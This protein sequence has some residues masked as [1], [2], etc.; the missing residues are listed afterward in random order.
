M[1]K[2]KLSTKVLA[3]IL[4]AGMVV[5]AVP[6]N[7]FA[8]DGA[9]EGLEV[10]QAEQGDS[11]LSENTGAQ[12]GEGSVSQ[13]SGNETGKEGD[14]G[15]SSP[16]ENGND[17][18]ESGNDTSENDNDT[19]ES[20]NN[21]TGSGDEITEGSGNTLPSDGSGSIS[22]TT[23]NDKNTQNTGTEDNGQSEKNTVQSENIENGGEDNKEDGSVGKEGNKEEGDLEKEQSF[24]DAEF[25]I[26]W[27]D[28][29]N[30]AG[31]RPEDIHDLIQ[32]YGDGTQINDTEY[33][34]LLVETSE[35]NGMD[36]YVYR[37]EDLPVYQ[38]DLVTEI[39][40]SLKQDTE[41]IKGYT[42][43]SEQSFSDLDEVQVQQLLQG[44][45]TPEGTVELEKT[46]GSEDSSYHVN[47]AFGNYL[48]SYEV[49]GTISWLD[50]NGSIRPSMEQYFRD[51]FAILLDGAPYKTFHM[52]YSDDSED[53]SEW[54]YTIKGLFTTK[55]DGTPAVYTL[56]AG[57]AEGYVADNTEI[58]ISGDVK[59]AW[60]EY[61]E[62][63][64]L[65]EVMLYGA[66]QDGEDNT[67]NS[68]NS[69]N[70][71]AKAEYNGNAVAAVIWQDVNDGI[72]HVGTLPVQI[73]YAID[74]GSGNSKWNTVSCSWDNETKA[75]VPDFSYEQKN[76]LVSLG[77]TEEDL[78]SGK[79]S[80]TG[81]NNLN[82]KIQLSGMPSKITTSDAK[83]D[84]TITEK[85]TNILWDVIVT[86]APEASNNSYFFKET[87]STVGKRTYRLT[88]ATE[89]ILNLD[90]RNG[91]SGLSEKLGQKFFDA[92]KLYFN[93]AGTSYALDTAENGALQTYISENFGSNIKLGISKDW[94][95]SKITISGLPWCD[96]N[97]AEFSYCIRVFD[98][99][100]GSGENQQEIADKIMVGDNSGDYY[101]VSYN[102]S[103]VPN[104]GDVYT[105]VYNKGTMI[106]RLTGFT[107][108]QATKIWLDEKVNSEE[109]PQASWSLWRYSG[110]GR[111]DGYQSASPVYTLTYTIDGNNKW[112]PVTT[113]VTQVLSG[114]SGERVS[115]NSLPKYNTDGYPYIYFVKESMASD[116]GYEKVF[117]NVG[118][119][120]TV[121]GDVLPYGGERGKDTSLYNGGV[122]SN[123]M[124][125]ETEASQ[126][127]IWRAAYY[128]DELQDI[129]VV[130]KLQSRQKNNAASEWTDVSLSGSDGNL[131]AATQEI[132][133]F[134]LEELSKKVSLENLPR[135]DVWGKELEYRWIE[136]ALYEGSNRE[137]NLL[138]TPSDDNGNKV[139]SLSE[140]ERNAVDG[141][142]HYVSY[143]A[144]EDSE[145]GLV[146][147]GMI[148]NELQGTTDYYVQKHWETDIPDEL[149]SIQVVLEQR[150][151]DGSLK[152]ELTYTV[153][154]PDA[155]GTDGSNV[156]DG[157]SGADGSNVSDGTNGADGSGESDERDWTLMITGYPDQDGTPDPDR[158]LPK[159]DETGAKY[160]YM[161]TQE[162]IPDKYQGQWG[163]SY[164]YDLTDTS[165]SIDNLQY[166]VNNV[167]ITNSAGGF[168]KIIKVKKEW[169]DD[170]DALNRKPVTIEVYRAADAS[171]QTDDTLL[172]TVTLTAQKEWWQYVSVTEY[173]YTTTDR[174]GNIQTIISKD[175]KEAWSEDIDPATDEKYSDLEKWKRDHFYSN[176]SYYIME[177]GM[178]GE[179]PTSY[180]VDTVNL[181]QRGYPVIRTDKHTYEVL[182]K[183]SG[184]VTKG[185]G[186]DSDGFYTVVNRRIGVENLK[187][188]KV[189]KDGN[190]SSDERMRWEASFK[191]KCVEYPDA[192]GESVIETDKNDDDDQDNN[193]DNSQIS[194]DGDET[195]QDQPN[196]SYY[197]TL[198]NDNG[199][200]VRQLIK[201]KEGSRQSYEVKLTGVTGT[202]NIETVYYCNLPKYDLSGRVIHYD[203]METSPDDILKTEGEY[204]VEDTDITYVSSVQEDS[205]TT[206]SG[207]INSSITDSDI[208]IEK[209]VTNQRI[210]TKTVTFYKK[211]ID[212][213]VFEDGKRPDIYLTIYQLDSD[214]RCDSDN[215]GIPDT[216]RLSD[217]VDRL[218]KKT[219]D[220]TEYDWACEVQMPKY[221]STGRE[222]IYYAVESTHVDTASLDYLPVQYQPSQEDK[223]ADP[224]CKDSEITYENG[225]Y[226]VE[227]FESLAVKPVGNDIWALKENGT[228]VKQLW[229]NITVVGKKV[230]ENVPEGF[231]ADELPKLK[232]IL[233]RKKVSEEEASPVAVAETVER[234]SPGL[235]FDFTFRYEGTNDENGNYV[236]SVSETDDSGSGTTD[237]WNRLLPK[238]DAQTGEL[239]TYSVAEKVTEGVG[240]VGSTEIAYEK[241]PGDIHNYVIT[242]TYRR[243]G[244]NVGNITVSKNWE[245]FPTK[246]PGYQYPE[247]QFTLYRFYK[248]KDGNGYSTPE[249]VATK[250]LNCNGASAVMF[251]DQLIYAPN[252][253]PYIYFVQEK[254]LNG[255]TIASGLGIGANTETC[256]AG[257]ETSWPDQLP[258]SDRVAAAGCS[259]AFTIQRTLS[260]QASGDSGSNPVVSQA[261][262]DFTNTFTGNPITT[263]KGEKVWDD[264]GDVF[265]TRQDLNLTLFR[266]AQKQAGTSVDNA[267][268][269]QKVC[270]VTVTKNQSVI[271]PSEVRSV[272]SSFNQ[273]GTIKYSY[274]ARGDIWSYTFYNLDGYA[275]NSS[276]W[277]YKVVEGTVDYDPENTEDP[278]K[279]TVANYDSVDGEGKPSDGV[280]YEATIISD[281]SIDGLDQCV[282]LGSLKNVNKTS[283]KVTKVWD[284]LENLSQPEVTFALQVSVDGG[285]N[286]KWAKSYFGDRLVSVRPDSE[287]SDSEILSYEYTK[288]I[289]ANSSEE[290]VVFEN[291]PRY[292]KNENDIVKLSYRAMEVMVGSQAVYFT[293]DTQTGGADNGVAYDANNLESVP[294]SGYLD[295]QPFS[296][297]YQPENSVPS[298][299]IGGAAIADSNG[300]AQWQ[301]T[302]TNS[303]VGGTV[304]LSVTKNWENDDNNS[305]KTRPETSGNFWRV[306]FRL[307]RSCGNSV[308]SVDPASEI[309]LSGAE[310]SDT[311]YYPYDF[312]ITSSM[313]SE[314]SGFSKTLDKLPKYNEYGQQ[315]TYF[316]REINRNHGDIVS[317]PT[318]QN[319]TVT[320]GDT[321]VTELAEESN[322]V[323]NSETV[324]NTLKLIDVVGKKQWT[325]DENITG[326]RPDITDGKCEEI[327]LT[328]YVSDDGGSTWKEAFGVDGMWPKAARI[329]PTWVDNNDG[330][331]TW[332]FAGLPEKDANGRAYTYSVKEARVT[333]YNDAIYEN[334][335]SSGIGFSDE[336][337]NYSDND[338]NGVNNAAVTDRAIGAV[339]ETGH[340][341]APISTITNTATEF[342]LDKVGSDNPD[343]KLHHVTLTFVEAD[344]TSVGSGWYFTWDRQ[345][346][347]G[348]DDTLTV[349]ETYT[350]YY[351][352]AEK[353]SGT[354]VGESSV[355]IKGVPVSVYK[356]FAESAPYGYETAVGKYVTIEVKADGTI[357]VSPA[358]TIAAGSGDGIGKATLSDEPIMISLSKKNAANDSEITDNVKAGMVFEITG[359]FRESDSTLT[360]ST[361]K[362]IVGSNAALPSGKTEADVLK[363]GDLV[364]GQAY[365]IKELAAPSGFVLDGNTYHFIVNAD[366][367]I[368]ISDEG[369][370]VVLVSEST[371]TFKNQAIKVILEKADALNGGNLLTGAEFELK[372]I[373]DQADQPFKTVSVGTSGA[374]LGKLTLTGTDSN[375]PIIQNHTYVLKE[376]KAADGYKLIDN[377]SV[378]FTV[379]TD[380]KVS[381][382]PDS[383]DENYFRVSD[384]GKTIRVKNDPIQLNLVKADAENGSI[385]LENAVFA[386]IKGTN[387]N[388]APAAS[389]TTGADGTLQ[390][391]TVKRSKPFI[392]AAGNYVLKETTAPA[393]YKV[394]KPVKF[395]IDE[396]GSVTNLAYAD[397]TSIETDGT[398]NVT[399]STDAAKNSTLTIQDEKTLFTL[400]KLGKDGESRSNLN[401]V[402]LKILDSGRNEILT[403][404]RN[405][406]GT[407]VISVSDSYEYKSLIETNT[408]AN[409][410]KGLPAGNYILTEPAGTAPGNYLII[411][412]YSFSVNKDG[413]LT[414]MTPASNSSVVIDNT[415]GNISLT[416]TDELVRG[417][418]QITKYLGIKDGHKTL[419]G[420]EFELYEGTSPNGTR[421]RSSKT[422]V[423]GPDGK[424]TVTG[425]EIG[426]YYFKETSATAD[427]KLKDEVIPF[428]ITANV[429][430][431]K[432]P[433]T[434]MLDATN[435]VFAADVYFYKED[436]TDGTRL[437]NATFT[438]VYTPVTTEA[439]GYV[440]AATKTYK[441]ISSGDDKGKVALTGLTKGH[442]VLTETAAEG[443]YTGFQA[444]F[445][446]VESDGGKTGTDAKKLHE[447][448]NFKVLSGTS[449]G[450]AIYDTSTNT[451]K[452][453]RIPGSVA[454]LKEDA[455]SY[456]DLDGAVFTLKKVSE[457]DGTAVEKSWDFMFTTGETYCYDSVNDSF[458]QGSSSEFLRVTG[459]LKIMGLDWGTY[460]LT[461]TKAPDGYVL[462]DTPVTKEFSIT[463]TER[464]FTATVDKKGVLNV[465]NSI[466]LQKR[467]AS[468]SAGIVAL[469][470][471]AVYTLAP[472]GA[473]D[474]FADGTTSAK[475]YTIPDGSDGTTIGECVLAGVLVGGNEY[476][477]IETKAP[478]GYELPAEADRSVTFK[479]N[480]NGTISAIRESS[481]GQTGIGENKNTVFISDKKISLSLEKQDTEGNPING[482]VLDG[483]AFTVKGRFAQSGSVIG[484]EETVAVT[485]VNGSLGL[486]ALDGKWLS[487]TGDTE[488]TDQF[489]Y[490]L[491][492]T[493]AP[494]G[495]ELPSETLKSI[496]FTVDTEGH[497]HMT[498]NTVYSVAANDPEKIIVKDTPVEITVT[499]TNA[500][501]I[502]IGDEARGYAEF[503]VEGIFAG[504]GETRILG[505][506]KIENGISDLSNKLKGKLITT[507]GHTEGT[508]QFTYRLTETKAPD[509]YVLTDLAPYVSFT[510]D[511]SGV[512]HFEDKD[513]NVFVGGD[514]PTVSGDG[515][516]NI[517]VKNDTMTV[518]LSKADINDKSGIDITGGQRGEAY[519]VVSP[520]S[521][522]T[523]AD[524]N[525]DPITVH[526]GNNG[527]DALTGMLRPD[528]IYSVAE[529]TAP[530]GYEIAPV[531]YIRVDKQGNLS[532]VDEQGQAAAADHGAVSGNCLTV[533]DKKIEVT[534]MKTDADAAGSTQIHLSGAVFKVKPATGND[535]FVTA[536]M[537]EEGMTVTDE[538]RGSVF[539]GEL[540]AGNSYVISEI[541][542]PAGYELAD[543]VMFTVNQDGTVTIPETII[544]NGQEQK[545]GPGTVIIDTSSGNSEVYIRIADEQIEIKLKKAD[546]ETGNL[547]TASSAEFS[548]YQGT[549]IVSDKLIQSGITTVDGTVTLNQGYIGS[550]LLI[551]T[552]YTLVETKTPDGYGFAAPVV[553]QIDEHGNVKSS[554]TN[555]SAAGSEITVKDIKTSTNKKQQEEQ[556]ADAVKTG[557]DTNLMLLWMM[558]AL[559]GMAMLLLERRRRKA[560]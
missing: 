226:G 488:G 81:S 180:N 443:Y 479:M 419:S 497:V 338:E 109:R 116:S 245:N 230:W 62:E 35:E 319:Y 117:G 261:T 50:E 434:V 125:G 231:P 486:D 59:D 269:W 56:A 425:L 101:A 442:Y 386:L 322:V 473:D 66:V 137:N 326:L 545:N 239:Y 148:V 294:A 110:E 111:A 439:A 306:W 65:S 529:T 63:A 363:A 336:E 347:N 108:Y 146:K 291:L 78:L 504:I 302:V 262:V 107:S 288:T 268:S 263:V 471:G 283:L 381:F 401:D 385:K 312:Y 437:D 555:A 325:G 276:R 29:S 478:Y 278:I 159:F 26:S 7:V 520:I 113:Q 311:E 427:S 411:P 453:N 309:V 420:V 362:Y 20:G 25:S 516:T 256:E 209:T 489:T 372:D 345:P 95:N 143:V 161:V 343:V 166:G 553:F 194:N 200:F 466:I 129:T 2:R 463:R 511:T 197:V 216:L 279:G 190:A 510:V 192:V 324:T 33:E 547:I 4:A 526:T 328:L 477:L 374:G 181:S 193:Q 495:Y 355:V 259:P 199:E 509:G 254:E 418:V 248:Y 135:Y 165:S 189:W 552:E 480:T 28:E 145:D 549:E 115:W 160:T 201:N 350:L 357:A 364:S 19:S 534:L 544:T 255:Y 527:T 436:G 54:S 515:T 6:V 188:D 316:V 413:T 384:D 540:I 100:T 474:K 163:V 530:K 133:G 273:H 144:S 11:Q 229:D 244:N 297:R 353:W 301:H 300:I 539:D 342:I 339:V 388:D 521:S 506:T 531:V 72:N 502:S 213:S 233:K 236:V 222:I 69:E 40:Y 558:M 494:A 1:K 320:Y 400:N 518:N 484:S 281:N 335:Q 27:S 150:S 548:L 550:P 383:F 337:E 214:P 376:T 533:K 538:N 97:K 397:G 349:Q 331:W 5:N 243:T 389:G 277:E 356:L 18:S 260:D 274:D 32:I 34:I 124:S 380:G 74:E 127:K 280:A 354:S 308:D 12:T 89:F 387:I 253:N 198:R 501:G 556:K 171:A 450:E 237:T 348:S 272:E 77:F 430:R 392:L 15:K 104:F 70:P 296:V 441:T 130:M 369:Q 184:D 17:I 162:I 378:T 310:K 317:S 238:Y 43:M 287:N 114:V 554:I 86:G 67:Q 491:T 462:P 185:T 58:E 330:T 10:E 75:Y 191:I 431:T 535:S 423:T 41:A 329:E 122:L 447:T 119:D 440:S 23:G 557:D 352:G 38:K 102:N 445:D 528:T 523:F 195:G 39:Q 460:T 83:I 334:T 361:A 176:G 53:G 73:R 367:T 71:V 48:P 468:T 454:I 174:E 271:E 206:D 537:N 241:L 80:D 61:A 399:L 212:Q 360:S 267:L 228:F 457:A 424:L 250:S 92:M 31:R 382:L 22:E 432:Q 327:D 398:A 472:R 223:T 377:L 407:V 402:T 461:E 346:V 178:A 139:F 332:R 120:G 232:F 458:F 155:D 455:S 170:G 396:Y 24:L 215:D 128:Q 196:E 560:R 395:I 393:G 446:I 532:I 217:Y 121:A 313:G 490:T 131:A 79:L 202:D 251:E 93:A 307:F 508:D 414:A 227:H 284:Q 235:S 406:D 507:N 409:T 481:S 426:D 333:G 172:D 289:A 522:G 542:A 68:E 103:N 140:N 205:E 264:F 359:R 208:T 498:G 8:E 394:M 123:R 492:E 156:S 173:K 99:T 82:R 465:K 175:P 240:N 514:N 157:T 371:I 298:D 84:G 142:E 410:I 51:Q 182:Y 365:S 451:V 207:I 417:D 513:T 94:A 136:T 290:T 475:A 57:E 433:D 366:G 483:T 138:S 499:K 169:L 379:D 37:I 21:I 90:V 132:N 154:R 293:T 438:L 282:T 275:P 470:P 204:C 47:K 421:I 9:S 496:T 147:E 448:V 91:S 286:W 391:I 46:A 52:D 292:V 303:P 183:N 428:A 265:E 370:N 323:I 42:K 252:F 14:S 449:G 64:A 16:A 153:R 415:E 85:V 500:A 13:S 203:V 416:A 98:T 187:V 36:T 482:D 412:D 403:W 404:S 487:S 126:T 211:W 221:D 234:Q 96:E 242:N 76:E 30:L 503:K 493:K 3:W 167:K 429:D 270:E 321:A 112:H 305:F 218:W 134:T 249:A 351:N 390:F 258:L 149:N 314:D 88:P 299:E 295:P 304:S 373:T 179:N 151:A 525:S 186:T 177:T 467:D 118:E 225:I 257:L 456:E 247:V 106:L 87:D 141:P 459:V 344:K 408:S 551:D 485:A 358:G 524:G 519:F 210:K 164:A 158:P 152:Q 452:N 340:E 105:S 266:R 49:S 285:I 505:T 168:G 546:Y 435:D 476:V 60:I 444:E 543:S 224:K 422:L 512:L 368:A 541:T 559:S 469:V 405:A 464:D 219:G 517:S 45:E 55:S 375:V 220:D 246:L 318:S 536:G 44:M 315:Y 341:A